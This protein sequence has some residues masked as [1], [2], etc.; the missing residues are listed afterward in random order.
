MAACLEAASTPSPEGG[1]SLSLSIFPWSGNFY[2][3][4]KKPLLGAQQNQ[5]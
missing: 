1:P 4:L 5:K 3:K 2:P